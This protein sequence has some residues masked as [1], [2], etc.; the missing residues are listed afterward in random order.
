[1]A[2]TTRWDEVMVERLR[3]H[4]KE[5]P[6][7]LS[8]CLDEGQGAFLVALR[9]VIEAGSG[10]AEAASK[11]RVHRVS[12]YK[13]L[14]DNGNPTLSS[15]AKVLET[16]GLRLSVAPKSG[17]SKTAARKRAQPG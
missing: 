13:M 3:E 9:H 2:L 1:M 16:M 11:A 6:G 14:G 8:A 12:L 17:A 15:L 7:Y 5:I 10:M 4:P